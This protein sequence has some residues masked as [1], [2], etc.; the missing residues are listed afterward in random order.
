[1]KA[2]LSIIITNYNKSP[3]EIEDCFQ[4]IKD[5]TVP[6]GEVIFVDDHSSLPHIPSDA[7]SIILPKNM[8]VAFARDIGV[9]MAKHTLLLFLDADDKLAPDFIEKCGKKLRGVH[10]AGADIVYTDVLTFGDVDRNKLYIS[11]DE[12]TPEYLLG[13]NLAIRVTSLMYK[14]MYED[15]GGFRDLPIFED[16]DFWLRAAVKGYTFARAETI[17]WYRQGKNSRSDKSLDLRE[18]IHKKITAPF[19]VQEGKLVWVQKE[20]K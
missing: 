6:P 9:R 18:E 20:Q 15:L 17:L 10:Q 19:A 8:G 7:I 5:Q 16:W 1:M 11:P 2:N 3:Q 12:I 14:K 13:K 4:S